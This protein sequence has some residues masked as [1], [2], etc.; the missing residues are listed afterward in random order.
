MRKTAKKGFPD[1]F[2]VDWTEFNKLCLQA[3]QAL[4]G[5]VPS[6]Y[7]DAKLKALFDLCYYAN[8]RGFFSPTDP[9]DTPLWSKQHK[10]SEKDQKR[11]LLQ[12][13]KM[14]EANKPSTASKV[15]SFV[16]FCIR[17][18]DGKQ[19]ELIHRLINSSATQNSVGGARISE[20]LA[21]LQNP[22]DAFEQ[23]VD[24]KDQ[25]YAVVYGFERYTERIIIQDG[26]EDV[27]HEIRG[28]L[29]NLG[30]NPLFFY[31]PTVFTDVLWLKSQLRLE[32][33]EMSVNGQTVE[34]RSQARADITRWQ[35]T[36]Q[37]GCAG[38]VEIRFPRPLE[39]YET[40]GFRW[41]Y[42]SPGSLNE[43]A[44]GDYHQVGVNAP[45]FRHLVVLEC[46]PKWRF[47][48]IVIDAGVF[49]TGPP[50]ILRWEMVFPKPGSHRV[51]FLM[52]PIH[53]AGA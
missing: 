36:G 17:A 46:R 14:R 51:R 41:A 30:K 50:N 19:T 33:S 5:G 23:L 11:A 22:T 2:G 7:G 25:F 10:K 6:S 26:K 27:L 49:V 9:L 28:V 39:Q 40:V 3:M 44:T 18:T 47:E 21:Q 12:W 53:E 20:W 4:I 32:L 31:K 16:D 29:I 52:T 34:G 13:V 15:E 8:A 43:E 48:N 35:Q 42:H 1:R 45:I 37:G 24:G 38:V